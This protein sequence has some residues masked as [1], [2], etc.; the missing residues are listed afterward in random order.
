MS[1]D[2]S[3]VARALI[4]EIAN[5]PNHNDPER[6]SGVQDPLSGKVLEPGEGSERLGERVQQRLNARLH[7]PYGGRYEAL[8]A[9]RADYTGPDKAA[10]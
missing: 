3:T 6:V 4:D 10:A 8:L 2:F 5:T 7:L 1:N 9:R